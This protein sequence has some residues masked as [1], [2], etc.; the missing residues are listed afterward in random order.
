MCFSNLPIEFDD[1]GN[2]YLA[3]EAED[4]DRPPASEAEFES[5]CG[6]AEVTD[7]VALDDAD[8]EFLYES[9]LETMPSDVRERLTDSNEQP[10]RVAEHER[11][12][13]G[14]TD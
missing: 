11:P 12:E 14:Q 5:T 9:I 2:P 4:V 13:P 8:P 10:G 7:D 1:E 3:E 6:C